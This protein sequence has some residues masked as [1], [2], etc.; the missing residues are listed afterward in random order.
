MSRLAA[1]SPTWPCKAWGW[2]LVAPALLVTAALLQP[3][4][5]TGAGE[6]PPGFECMLEPKMVV[7]L[8][9]QASGILAKVLIDRGDRVK[10]GQAVAMLESSVEAHNLAVVRWR[11]DNNIEVQLAEEAAALENA[12]FNRR[13][14]LWS[15]KTVSEE[16]FEKARTDAK[17]RKLEIE[18]AKHARELARLEAARAQAL[19]DIRT[20]NSPV[21]GIVTA[22]RMSPGE[23]V[24]DES[25]IME[26]A[27]ID[28]LYVHAF[29]PT[30]AFRRVRI[31]TLG[32][33]VLEDDIGGSYKARVTVKDA[34]IDA[35]SST[36]LTRL[37]LPNPDY[38][39][40]SGARC[41]VSFGAGD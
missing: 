2:A 35:A 29:L 31:G 7:R 34:V 22:R 17:L 28:P 14:T 27:V 20:I 36:F 11:A 10:S 21:D 26:I 25:Q 4:Q 33:V 8:G 1:N 13:S 32:H 12:R 3:I 18:R 5:S 38:R 39:I 16:V 41:S 6:P 19:L 9:A 15:S 30:A 37:E 24:R 40:P 23:F